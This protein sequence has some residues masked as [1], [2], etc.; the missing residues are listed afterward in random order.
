M[1]DTSHPEMVYLDDIIGPKGVHEIE[2]IDGWPSMG[3]RF[4]KEADARH[5]LGLLVNASEAN[6][7]K[8]DTFT[9]D[10]MP[11]R[12]HFSHNKRIAPIYVVPKIGYALTTRKDGYDMSKGV[13][14]S[15]S[16][17]TKRIL[18]SVRTMDTTM[19]TSPCTLCSWPMVPLRRS[20]KPC[21][22]VQPASFLDLTGDG[23]LYQK[24]HMSWMNSET[25]K[26][27]GLS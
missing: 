15:T 8:F 6:P 23:T 19:K 9:L 3:L 5:Y 22:S 21:S 13:S 27:M 2:H 20:P 26:S 10:T 12:Y 1:T 25:W 4:D 14:H 18:M 17:R 7:E 24:I 16:L 11:E